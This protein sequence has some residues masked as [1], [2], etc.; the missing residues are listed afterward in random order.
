MF[1]AN[2][3]RLVLHTDAPYQRILELLHDAFVYP[4]TEVLYRPSGLWEHDRI[5][6]VWQFALQ[7]KSRY[8]PQMDHYADM[9]DVLV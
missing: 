8:R 7:C 1:S 2:L 5:I 9:Q 3:L 4:V 6:V